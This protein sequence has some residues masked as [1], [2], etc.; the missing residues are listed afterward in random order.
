MSNQHIPMNKA[1]EQALEQAMEKIEEKAMDATIER[2]VESSTTAQESQDYEKAK[3][4]TFN[5][6]SYREHSEKEVRVYLTNKG[7]SEST[8]EAVIERMK[9]LDYI[10]DRRFAEM[11]TKNR[12][13]AGRKG[14]NFLKKELLEKGIT[15]ELIENII[16]AEYNADQEYAAALKAALKKLKSYQKELKDS[17]SRVA[18]KGRLWRFL[19]QRGFKGSTVEKVVYQVLEEENQN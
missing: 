12:A 3:N 9:E 13:E 18:L 14:P 15:E 10:N 1:M 17:E 4:L 6:L 8:I 16:G 5:Y 2:I 19:M 11:W 7:F